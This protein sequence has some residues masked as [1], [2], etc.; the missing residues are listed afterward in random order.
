MDK[1]LWEIVEKLE[2][3][4]SA[5]KSQQVAEAREDLIKIF[6]NPS[7]SPDELA[8]IVEAI[9]TEMTSKFTYCEIMLICDL[10]N[11]T[12]MPAE[13]VRSWPQQLAWE[14]E[15]GCNLDGLDKKWEIK[16]E[17]LME[18]VKALSIA[19]VWWLVHQVKVWWYGDGTYS[20]TRTEEETRRLFRI[21]L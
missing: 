3:T 10:L 4:K 21:P 5:F 1:K 14:V 11:G 8:G 2:K 13:T 20:N 9:G 18:K 17:E 12:I 15:D 6:E 16:K 19:H 7:Y